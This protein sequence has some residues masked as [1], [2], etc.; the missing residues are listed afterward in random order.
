[1]SGWNLAILILDLEYFYHLEFKFFYI[2]HLESFDFWNWLLVGLVGLGIIDYGGV[3][4]IRGMPLYSVIINC[5]VNVSVRPKWRSKVKTRWG[6]K[7]FR[8]CTHSLS[9][10]LPSPPLY[11]YTPCLLQRESIGNNGG[12]KPLHLP[13]Q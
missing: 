13:Q 1:M 12:Q 2:F 6:N 5:F 8:I 9:H 3:L 11:S 7:P 4:E 10:T